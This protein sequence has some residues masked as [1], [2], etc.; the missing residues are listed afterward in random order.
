[1]KRQNTFAKSHRTS[2]VKKKTIQNIE[3]E[4]D[5]FLEQCAHLWLSNHL[6]PT[7]QDSQFIVS[8]VIDRHLEIGKYKK[9]EEIVFDV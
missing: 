6:S 2:K 9:P 5:M 4:K 1:M 7:K 8:S 3:R